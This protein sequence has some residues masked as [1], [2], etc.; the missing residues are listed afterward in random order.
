MLCMINTVGIRGC[1]INT[2]PL[3][4]AYINDLAGVSIKKMDMIADEESKTFKGVWDELNI[5]AAFTFEHAVNRIQN[6]SYKLCRLSQVIDFGKLLEADEIPPATEWRG[7]SLESNP[8]QGTNPYY[9]ESALSQVF[10][11]EISVWSKDAQ[12]AVPIKVF[13]LSDGTVL[14]STTK[15]LVAGW[16]DF[17][18]NTA[19]DALNVFVAYWGGAVTTKKIQ[20]KNF[21]GC[22]DYCANGCCTVFYRSATFDAT[23]STDT[24]VPASI[25]YDYHSVGLSGCWSLRCSWTNL[26]CCAKK[27]FVYAWQNLLG[28]EFFNE[29]TSTDRLNRF[30]TI[31]RKN[32]ERMKGEYFADFQ[33]ALSDTLKG[34]SIDQHDCCVECNEV[35]TVKEFHP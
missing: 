24:V 6:Q 25:V 21:G 17:D 9:K 22:S 20:L 16:N 35:L 14:Y 19:F 7:Y 18:I 10:V 11:D 3:F 15:D 23:L 4:P 1:G 26:V 30:T 8:H 28:Y 33:E 12:T 32:A 34:I 29:V 31:D 27:E 13:D 2:T 5:R